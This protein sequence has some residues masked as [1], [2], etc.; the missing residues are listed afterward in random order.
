M[1]FQKKKNID[2]EKLIGLTNIKP[3]KKEEVE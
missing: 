2:F 3:Q 1:N